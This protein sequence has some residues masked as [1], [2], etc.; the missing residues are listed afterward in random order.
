MRTI[1]GALLLLVTATGGCATD[2][3]A[4]DPSTADPWPC[5]SRTQW[6]DGRNTEQTYQWD[7]HHN[8][9]LEREANGEFFKWRF[10]PSG[11]IAIEEIHEWHEEAD[12]Y[13]DTTTREL[14]DGRVMKEIREHERNGPGTVLTT[15][16]R[17]EAGR[18]VEKHTIGDLATDILTTVSYPEPGVREEED[19][20]RSGPFRDGRF[21]F[22][23]G[24]PWRE[25]HNIDGIETV[26]T[27]ELDAQGRELR[28]KRF[29]PG[30]LAN[31]EVVEIE[32][33]SNGAPVREVWTQHD[34]PSRTVTY[35][36]TCP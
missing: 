15:T 4:P 23:K 20:V 32:R 6:A 17:Y 30:A 1:A 21:R 2:P 5:A 31:D 16:F 34:A 18:L 14:V 9:V 35:L 33:D 36:T 27:R 12:T 8:L 25:F 22:W 29:S 28:V 7:E 24:D 3:D 19:D 13:R 11:T 10:D 26:T